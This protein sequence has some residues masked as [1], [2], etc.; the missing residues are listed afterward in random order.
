MLRTG[1]KR[2]GKVFFGSWRRV[3]YSS[4]KLEYN[5]CWKEL[6][7]SY[8]EKK[9]V[10]EYIENVWLPLKE[11]FVNAWTDHEYLHFGNR[12]SSKAELAHDKLK[13]I[14]QF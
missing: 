7:S 14:L 8:A 13:K 10:V 11:N 3:I 2:I 1:P 4:T 6:E 9:E 5:E 12:A